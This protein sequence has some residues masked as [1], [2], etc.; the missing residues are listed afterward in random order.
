M[1]S[2]LALAVATKSQMRPARAKW[3]VSE[4][5]AAKERRGW[6]GLFRGCNVSEENWRPR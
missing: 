1:Q 4:A 5:D 6:L 3:V 2:T